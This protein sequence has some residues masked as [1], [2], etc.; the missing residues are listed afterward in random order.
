MYAI[1]R[2]YAILFDTL[3]HLLGARDR[4]RRVAG[5]SDAS[6]DVPSG[7]EGV[8]ALL[9]E[10]NELNQQVAVEILEMAGCD[11]SLARNGAE[12]VTAVI[13]DRPDD[14]SSAPAAFDI[15]LMDVQMP[16]MDGLEATRRIRGV[17][18]FGALPIIAMT[19]NAMS[20]DRIRCLEAG[21]NDYITKP[22][23]PDAMFGVIGRFVSRASPRSGAP[24]AR[25]AADGAIPPIPGID[26]VAGLRRVVGNASLYLDLLRRFSEA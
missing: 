6:V 15:V 25:P 8:R 9:V 26:T 1:R 11:V 10:D 21:M 20:E 22:I 14:A 23:D 18:G 19:A 13:G 12:A 7:L 16:V 24:V 3:M 4:E 2:Y 5:G 17:P